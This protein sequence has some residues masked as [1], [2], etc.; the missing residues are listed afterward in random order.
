MNLATGGNATR[1]SP[2]LEFR[3]S[4]P[5]PRAVLAFFVLPPAFALFP[6]LTSRLWACSAAFALDPNRINPH[7]SPFRSPRTPSPPCRHTLPHSFELL[8]RPFCSPFLCFTS[9]TLFSSLA[10]DLLLSLFD[11]F[12]QQIQTTIAPPP[13]A[14]Q[15]TTLITVFSID[16]SSPDCPFAV[17]LLKGL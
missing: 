14:F 15:Q 6:P 10:L 12:I 17:I 7:L 3:Y 1:G 13:T 2:T 5:P 9:I 8:P 16:F 4:P 11:F